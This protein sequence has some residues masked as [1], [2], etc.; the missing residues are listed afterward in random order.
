MRKAS[1]GC[2]NCY[3]TGGKLTLVPWG[4]L[5]GY[6]KVHGLWLCPPCKVERT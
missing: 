2:D 6:G 3:R 1:R 4:Q 5:K